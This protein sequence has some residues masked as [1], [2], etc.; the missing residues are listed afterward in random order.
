MIANQKAPTNKGMHRRKG[1]PPKWLTYSYDQCAD[2]GFQLAGVYIDTVKQR[3]NELTFEQQT[4][5]VG[6]IIPLALKRV[7]DK[8]E[9]LQITLNANPD[10]MQR[11]LNIAEHNV[12][13]RNEL[14]QSKHEVK[15]VDVV[16]VDAQTSDNHAQKVESG[17]TGGG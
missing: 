7:P 1:R 4:D 15:V 16:A 11:L 3:W 5:A 2:R 9:V 17:G 8:H 6:R 14:G 13:L 10:D 12:I